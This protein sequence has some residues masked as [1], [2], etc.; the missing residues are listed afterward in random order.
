MNDQRYLM[1][2]E[3][4]D[5]KDLILCNSILC[6]PCI[7]TYFYLVT[8]YYTLNAPTKSPTSVSKAHALS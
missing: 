8:D 5:D 6:Q 3:N 7:I 2:N 4:K 1:L